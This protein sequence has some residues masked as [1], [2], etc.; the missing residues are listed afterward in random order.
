MTF[1]EKLKT[2]K[3]LF[4]L[5]VCIQFITGNTYALKMAA[6]ST[7]PRTITVKNNTKESKEILY[8]A[9][10]AA[11]S[12][13]VV[14]NDIGVKYTAQTIPAESSTTIT[15]DNQYD[16]TIKYYSGQ[17]LQKTIGLRQQVVQNMKN[18]LAKQRQDI[19][20]LQKSTDKTCKVYLWDNDNKTLVIDNIQVPTTLSSE[21]YLDKS[22]KIV[23]DPLLAAQE[24]KITIINKTNQPKEISY[25][26]LKSVDEQEAF[27]EQNSQSTDNPKNRLFKIQK[28]ETIPA[29]GSI[30]VTLNGYQ[31]TYG[32]N[33]HSPACIK[34]DVQEKL[35]DIADLEK[36]IQE[37]EQRHEQ[38]QRNTKQATCILTPRDIQPGNI[39]TIND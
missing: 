18:D 29:N 33:Y 37:L 12:D 3:K 9:V 1:L 13:K 25:S 11:L 36:T 4:T 26:T 30:Q 32:I 34:K 5:C 35:Q 20:R 23:N 21:D 27:I 14:V 24:H 19:E 16:D 22:S 10:S 39:L 15:I 8:H 31:L 7:M 28:T 6:G 2:Y 17:C 38:M